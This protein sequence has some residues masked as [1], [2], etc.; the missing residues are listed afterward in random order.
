MHA[1]CDR[2]IS[3]VES[4]LFVT[5]VLLIVLSLRDLLYV[6]LSFNFLHNILNYIL[7]IQNIKKNI[8][9]NYSNF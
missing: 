1:I 2:D 9:A 7:K 8:S 5:E 6:G 3:Y 4:V